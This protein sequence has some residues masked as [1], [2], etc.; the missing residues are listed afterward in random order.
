MPQQKLL[1]AAT[2]TRHNEINIQILKKIRLGLG[3]HIWTLVWLQ[4]HATQS[5]THPSMLSL[6][7]SE[8]GSGRTPLQLPRQNQVLDLNP[9][10]AQ[11]LSPLFLLRPQGLLVTVPHPWRGTLGSPFSIYPEA[12]LPVPLA[13]PIL[14][15]PT[16]FQ[17][18]FSA[19]AAP[20]AK[21]VKKGK[22]ASS[23]THGRYFS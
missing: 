10:L 3:S 22:G 18:W 19:K 20:G 7:A 13:E 16:K 1:R 6:M 17:W 5:R 12:P 11:L 21:M 23:G 9:P 2:K 15:L 14:S 8:E 4:S